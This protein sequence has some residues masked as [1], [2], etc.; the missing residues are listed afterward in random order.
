MTLL[1]IKKSVAAG[2]LEI[3]A[4]RTVEARSEFQ[5]RRLTKAVKQALIY[6]Q[7]DFSVEEMAKLLEVTKQRAQQVLKLG[8]NYMQQHGW[9]HPPGK[10]KNPG[11]G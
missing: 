5:Q 11:P 6:L 3:S 8:V 10:R 7:N 1:E 2:R 9:L 4:E